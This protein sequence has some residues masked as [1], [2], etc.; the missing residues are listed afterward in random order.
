MADT[1]SGHVIRIVPSLNERSYSAH[2]TCGWWGTP[3]LSIHDAQDEGQEHV[4]KEE[5][6]AAAD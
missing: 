3:L 5:N 2:C 6:R 4:N 1:M